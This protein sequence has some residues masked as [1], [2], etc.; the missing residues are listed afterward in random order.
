MLDWNESKLNMPESFNVS[1][2]FPPLQN[3]LSSCGKESGRG[4]WVNFTSLFCPFLVQRL[5]N[6]CTF[7]IYKFSGYNSIDFAVLGLLG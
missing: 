5:L 4:K 2:F 7:L 6:K 1:T 3:F